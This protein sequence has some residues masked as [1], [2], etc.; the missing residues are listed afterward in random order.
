MPVRIGKRYQVQ[1]LPAVRKEVVDDG[2]HADPVCLYSP[3]SSS[4]SSTD[5][6]GLWGS[7][8]DV[9]LLSWVL[10]CVYVCVGGD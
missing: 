4:S 3:V 8:W 10:V 6:H 9:L 5:R 2:E 7:W 1:S